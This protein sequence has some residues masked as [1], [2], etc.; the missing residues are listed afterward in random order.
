MP[1]SYAHDLA[2]A[3]QRAAHGSPRS[4]AS[5][6]ALPLM[7]TL[8]VLQAW[9]S[10]EGVSLTTIGLLGLV[11]FAVQHQVS[12]GAA[13]RSIQAAAL[14]RQA[15]WLL[16]SQIALAASIA[17]LGMQDPGEQHLGRRDRRLSRHVLFATQDIVIDAYRV[18]IVW[19]TTSKG[20]RHRS[21]PYG[22]R[23]GMLL[24]SAGGLILA[25]IIGFHAVYFVMAAVMACVRRRDA[26]APEPKAA[27]PAAHARADRSSGLRRVLPR[28]D[29]VDEGGA[30]ARVHRA[31]QAR[32]Q[33]RQSHVDT[34]LSAAR[35]HEHRDRR[36]RESRRRP[37]RCCSACSS[38]AHDAE[39]RACIASMFVIGVLQALST[40]CFVLLALAGYDRGWLA[41]VIALREPHRRH[42]HGALLAFMAG[43]HEPPVHRHSVCAALDARHACRAR[44]CRRRAGSL[45]RRSVGRSSIV[46]CALPGDPGLAAAYRS[47]ATWFGE[48]TPEPARDRGRL[49]ASK[50]PVVVDRQRRVVR[51]SLAL[52]DRG[53]LR[54]AA[55]SAGSRPDSRCANRRVVRPRA[56]AIRPPRVLIR[57]LVHGAK[58]VDEA[59]AVEQRVE[60][61]ALWRR[62][63]RVVLESRASSSGR[64]AGAPC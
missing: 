24:A 8:T 31:L 58:R 13:R 41:T 4:W 38:A 40:A 47:C 11:G 43:N 23:L 29:T 5:Q 27:A 7:L 60:P 19:P 39:A 50:L 16:L 26:V 34:V 28:G 14:G 25:D 63:A 59:A 22:Y 21:I 55:P 18:E 57:L 37:A 35:L 62:E 17:L 46:V 6:A 44:C 64:S 49:R 36:D 32:R 33:H 52:V 30:R 10:Q 51:E 2:S 1:A 61:R 20:S 9:L 54:L 53:A 48:P 45:R 56:A 42:G 3:R 15:R 12:L